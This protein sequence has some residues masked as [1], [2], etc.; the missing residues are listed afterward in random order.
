MSDFKPWRER[1]PAYAWRS[2]DKLQ[3]QFERQDQIILVGIE[4]F[5]NYDD[6]MMCLYRQ[7]SIFGAWDSPHRVAGES[8]EN[9]DRVIAH[10]RDIQPSS[11]P[12]PPEPQAPRRRG[13]RRKHRD[14][15]RLR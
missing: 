12:K 4:V 13:G 15:P 14:T 2:D 1:V 9:R 8:D 3:A 7:T 11:T 6:A 10:L 5:G